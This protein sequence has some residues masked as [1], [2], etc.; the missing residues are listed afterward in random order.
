[1]DQSEWRRRHL[2]ITASRHNGHNKRSGRTM[3]SM[4]P[5]MVCHDPFPGSDLIDWPAQ[6]SETQ[7]APATG[8]TEAGRV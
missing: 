8:M 4:Q 5:A 1:M 7:L 2:T 6:W 3:Q